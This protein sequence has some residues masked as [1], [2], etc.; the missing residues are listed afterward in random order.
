M[1]DYIGAIIGVVG[2]LLGT[3][4]GFFLNYLAHKGSVKFVFL[5]DWKMGQLNGIFFDLELINTNNYTITLRDFSIQT[6]KGYKQ[7]V[8]SQNETSWVSLGGQDEN[9]FKSAIQR[10][11]RVYD[12]SLI[13]CDAKSRSMIRLNIKREDFTEE[14]FKKLVLSKKITIM[15]TNNKGNKKKQ[16]IKMNRIS[17]Q[18]YNTKNSGNNVEQSETE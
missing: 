14:A 12:A 5:G 11:F 16:T 6:E 7:I 9:P 13:R 1:E 8:T 4:L 2:T 18:K 3:I 15:Y 17:P 10:D